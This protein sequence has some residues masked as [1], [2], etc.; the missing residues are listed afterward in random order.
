MV[1]V[2]VTEILMAMTTVGIVGSIMSGICLWVEYRLDDLTFKKKK[3][4][5]EK[6]LKY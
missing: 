5:R 3:K 6:N 2:P 4:K 1:E